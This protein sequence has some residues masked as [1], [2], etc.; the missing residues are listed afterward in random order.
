MGATPRGVGC[1]V[2]IFEAMIRLDMVGA[3]RVG[4]TPFV[5]LALNLGFVQVLRR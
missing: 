4:E 3:A 1:L 2:A 5:L